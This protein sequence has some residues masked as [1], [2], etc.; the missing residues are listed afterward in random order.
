MMGCVVIFGYGEYWQSILLNFKE[1]FLELKNLVTMLVT[2]TDSCS[3]NSQEEELIVIYG[4]L[5]RRRITMHIKYFNNL[6]AFA[7]CLY[8][9][10]F[11]LELKM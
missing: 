6:L 8:W 4:T 2:H 11:M 5:T 1:L 7:N 10:F 9:M 3:I